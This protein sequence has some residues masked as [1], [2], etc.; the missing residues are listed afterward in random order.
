MEAHEAVTLNK[1]QMAKRL[2]VSLPTLTNWIDRWPDFPAD[3]RGTNGKSWSF[4]PHAVFDFL[5]ARREEEEKATIGRDE[6]LME[7]QLQFDDLFAEEE[8]PARSGFVSTKEQIDIWRLRDLKR[9][10]AERCGKLVIADQ[11]QDMMATAFAMLA[12]DTG[13]FLRQLARDQSWPDA[14]LRQAESRLKDV[15]LKSVNSVLTMLKQD[16]DTEH[17]RQLHLT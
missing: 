10:E 7:L 14:V 4:N 16:T 9:K 15:Q 12:R 17:E 1:A 6:K 8:Q 13:A 2:K 11:M 3:H 5:A